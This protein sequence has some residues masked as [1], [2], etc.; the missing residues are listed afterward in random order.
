VILQSKRG[1]SY[2]KSQGNQFRGT[3]LRGVSKNG[4]NNWQIL[5]FEESTKVYLGT[6]D[7]I[8]KAALLYDIFSIQNKCRK[9]KTNFSYTAKE[10]IAIFKIKSL[11]L[12]RD[13]IVQMK[14]QN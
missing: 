9:A 12:I 8:L 1:I 3:S 4:R 5:C 13:N 14:N 11:K 2:E 10:I 7:D 6:V